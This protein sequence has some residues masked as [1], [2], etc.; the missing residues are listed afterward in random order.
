MLAGKK[1]VVQTGYFERLLCGDCETLL[2]GY[3]SEFDKH[4]MKT[5]PKNIFPLLRGP[6]PD[7]L[8]VEI[9]NYAKFKLFH[10][11]V[12][13]R[14]A[15]SS[16]NTDPTISLGDHERVIAKMILTGDPGQPGDFPFVAS[17]NYDKNGKPVP[18]V[19]PLAKSSNKLE[20]RFDCYLLSYAYCDW[21]FV[22]ARPGPQWMV[23]LEEAFRAERRFVL[24]SGP[25]RESKSVNLFVD[26]LRKRKKP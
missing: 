20:D 18:M 10:L 8:T 3:E 9:P 1:R 22:D 7:A 2:S 12:F 26:T 4:W 19:A 23:T 5:I 15:V 13:W 16:F 24:L 17:L 21:M 6:E 14:A 11:S 25:L